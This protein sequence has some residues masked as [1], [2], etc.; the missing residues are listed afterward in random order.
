VDLVFAAV[1]HHTFPLMLV[2]EL[3]EGLRDKFLRLWSTGEYAEL[4]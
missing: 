2:D 3:L 4:N 1:Y